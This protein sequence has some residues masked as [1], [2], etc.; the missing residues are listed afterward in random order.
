METINNKG[1]MVPERS[2]VSAHNQGIFD[3]LQQAIGFVPNLYAYFAKNETA[4]GDY[5]A[6]QNRKST[7]TPKERE[8]INLVVSQVNDC[9]YCL[10]AHTA[11]AKMYGFNEEQILEIRNGH[12]PFNDKWNTLAQFVKEATI[13]RGKPTADTIN[14]LMIAGYSEANFIDIVMV[15][16]DKMISNFLH[17]ITHL[18]VDFP[19]AP[20]LQEHIA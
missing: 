15:I 11:L 18:P 10:A 17:G 14:A 1:F 12:A 19:T 9:A 8:I 6:L 2:D 13:N 3:N 7:L 16:G 4:L 20:A 5:L